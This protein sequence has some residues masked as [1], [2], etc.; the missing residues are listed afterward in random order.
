MNSSSPGR[1]KDFENIILKEPIPSVKVISYLKENAKYFGSEKTVPSIVGIKERR[2]MSID[3]NKASRENHRHFLRCIN[4][5]GSSLKLKNPEN[6][7]SPRKIENS[8]MVETASKENN[9]SPPQLNRWTSSLSHGEE[10][11]F[12]FNQEVRLQEV[13]ELENSISSNDSNDSSTKES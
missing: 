12:N 1:N 7:N 11:H 3:T 2:K 4:N 8:Y 6:S 5:R 9:F 10:N 13:C